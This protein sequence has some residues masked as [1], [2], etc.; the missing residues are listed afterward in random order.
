MDTQ[1]VERWSEDV[2]T[3]CLVA[4]EGKEHNLWV[5]LRHLFVAVKMYD[6]MSDDDR[7]RVDS[8]VKKSKML[9]TSKFDLREK[10][11][12][13]T[14]KE[15][16]PPHPLLNEKEKLKEKN[17]RTSLCVADAKADAKEDAKANAKENFRKECLEYVGQYDEQRLADFYY[18]W[19]ETSRDGKMRFERQRCWST[20][21]RLKRWMNNQYASECAA[22][23][24]RLGKLKQ[25]TKSDDATADV[26]R[27]REE[28]NARLEQEIEER[29]R[30][31]VSY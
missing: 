16:F 11:R 6:L 27:E 2:L 7:Q 15:S 26:A 24:I 23:A 9:F 14:E 29:K 4:R 22:A 12:K 3:V 30:G 25:K 31:A 19:S 10:K 5:L 13:K 1:T 21:N 18:Y 8:I 17:K 20:E 28:T